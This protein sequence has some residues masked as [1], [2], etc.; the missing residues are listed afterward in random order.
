VFYN[1]GFFTLLG[2][3]PFPLHLDIHDLGY[4]FT[5]WGL[6]LAL[7]AVFV[8][9]RLSRRFGDRP[10]LAGA[11]IGIVLVLVVMG[12]LHSS[13]TALIICVICSGMFFGVTNTL[14][15]QV[16]MESAT[17]PR[18]IASS[19]YS[20][21]RF[22]GGAAAPFI[23]G[24]LG[25]HVSVQSAFYVGA[26][27]TAIA[28]GVLWF[29]RTALV[30]ASDTEPTVQQVVAQDRHAPVPEPAQTR[31]TL[32][33]AVGGPSAR[34]VCAMTVPLARARASTVHVL[35]V[36]ER[37]ILAGEDVIDLESNSSARDL[38]DACVAELR[39]AGVPIIGELL[40]SF[41]THSD[42][43]DQILR[44]AAQL[45]ATAIV[46]GPETHNGPLAAQVTAQIAASAPSHVI[47][48]HP[49]AGPLGHPKGQSPTS[50]AQLWHSSHT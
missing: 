21:V 27:M 39:E 17:V 48:L 37:D 6:M 9:P 41:G 2:Y 34:E 19:A 44:R 23:A 13:Q 32:L 29:Y 25:E 8:A 26:G 33:V 50:P 20:F 10:G 43:S 7:F 3:A 28:V 47:V 42:V 31:G 30:P 45:S 24:K 35:H 11:L 14:M 1:F 4:T 12:V 36:I 46:L 5:G 16:V 40:H 22:C 15:T 49:A 38:L 18:P